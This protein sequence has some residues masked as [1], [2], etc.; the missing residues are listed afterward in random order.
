V[1]DEGDAAIE[2]MEQTSI[3]CKHNLSISI[4]IIKFQSSLSTQS[5]IKYTQQNVDLE[6]PSLDQMQLLV[7]IYLSTES[8]IA[9]LDDLLWAHQQ[10]GF[11]FA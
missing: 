10:N 2:I 11:G 5:H 7:Q 1:A 9:Y 6:N 4:S 3:H 8:E